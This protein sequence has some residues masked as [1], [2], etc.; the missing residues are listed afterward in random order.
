MIAVLVVGMRVRLPS[1]NIVRL[2]RAEGGEWV[3]EFVDSPRARGTV[4]FSGAWLR[5]RGQAV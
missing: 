4:D 3:C 5:T 2:L 1:G